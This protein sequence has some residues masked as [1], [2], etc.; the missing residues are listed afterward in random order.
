MNTWRFLETWR[1]KILK[2]IGMK[3]F[4]LKKYVMRVRFDEIKGHANFS[5]IA[6]ER[7]LSLYHFYSMEACFLASSCKNTITNPQPPEMTREFS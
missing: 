4:V 3:V 1:W 5:G 7:F 2:K 6:W